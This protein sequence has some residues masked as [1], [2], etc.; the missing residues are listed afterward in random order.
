MKTD[1]NL[2]S[3]NLILKS[4]ESDLLYITYTEIPLREIHLAQLHEQRFGALKEKFDRMAK[5]Y[6]LK[7]DQELDIVLEYINNMVLEYV[8][9]TLD[10][11]TNTAIPV[12]E[13][14]L[15]E[16]HDQRFKLLHKKFDTMAKIYKLKNKS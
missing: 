16:L 5:I 3:L 11:I 7:N 6:K 2:K 12:T 4:I 8:N 14:Y 13:Q 9:N 10:N 1:K 15:N